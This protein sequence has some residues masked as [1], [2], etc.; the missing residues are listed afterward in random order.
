MDQ[1]AWAISQYHLKP[2]TDYALG[3]FPALGRGFDNASIIDAT[4]I[5]ATSNGE[6]PRRSGP[7][8]Q[9]HR[10]FRG[11]DII[12]R[13][14]FTTPSSNVDKSISTIL[15]PQLP[16]A[17]S[18]KARCA[19]VL[20]DMLPG[21]LVDE[22]RLAVAAIYLLIRRRPTFSRH[23][24]ASKPRQVRLTDA[25][26]RAENTMARSDLPGHAYRDC[27]SARTF[28]PEPLT[29]FSVPVSGHS[30]IR[31]LGDLTRSSKR[32]GSA[33]GKFAASASLTTSDWRNYIRLFA[34]PVFLETLWTTLIFTLGVTVV[35]VGYQLDARIAL[36]LRAGSGR[37][38]SG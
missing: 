3:K 5:L 36:R 29:A 14:G 20:G 31:P 9:L 28:L 18:M 7:L 26:W 8:P 38:F 1:R 30:S 16:S 22:Y 4:E 17:T 19:F 11:A 35:S 32:C 10:E 21:S 23:S 2:G 12:A 37:R 25:I 27:E 13:A 34:D 24:N 33:S 15:L 6:N